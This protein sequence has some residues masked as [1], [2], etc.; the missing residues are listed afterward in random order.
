M[1]FMTLKAGDAIPLQ[2]GAASQPGIGKTQLAKAVATHLG[3]DYLPHLNVT[4]DP[5][6]ETPAMI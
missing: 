2:A 5:R 1:R 4:I 6:L 3:P